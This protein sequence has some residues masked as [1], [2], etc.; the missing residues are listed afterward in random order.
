MIHALHDHAAYDAATPIDRLIAH[1]GAWRVLAH[2]AGAILF[3]RRRRPPPT[4]ADRLSDYIRRDIGLE[5]EV[6]SPRHWEL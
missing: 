5:P 6:F 2:A 3:G 4:R 1:Y